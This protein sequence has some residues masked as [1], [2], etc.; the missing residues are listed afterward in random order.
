M[1]FF[2]KD[3][4]YWGELINYVTGSPLASWLH[5]WQQKLKSISRTPIKYYLN[6]FIVR[7][8]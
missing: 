6:T 2:L 3:C 5:V 8:Q 7:L 1:G 4:Y